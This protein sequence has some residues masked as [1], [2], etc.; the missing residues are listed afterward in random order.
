MKCLAKIFTIY[1]T[2]KNAATAANA[3]TANPSIE[4]VVPSTA[5]D[6]LQEMIRQ[7]G[8]LYHISFRQETALC[9]WSDSVV[10]YSPTTGGECFYL[11]MVWKWSVTSWRNLHS[12]W[13]KL[14]LIWLLLMRDVIMADNNTCK[15]AST[16]RYQVP[17]LKNL[18]KL[19]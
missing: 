13:W 9:D 5:P 11:S 14:T 10:L 12:L 8:K 18:C 2:S 17:V 16:Y 19:W 3:S 4:Q 15:I 1:L 7:E 6:N